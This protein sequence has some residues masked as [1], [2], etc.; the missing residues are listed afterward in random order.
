MN[1]IHLNTNLQI[2]FYSKYAPL[3][4]SFIICPVCP[5]PTC[6][7]NAK[8]VSGFPYKIVLWPFGSVHFFFRRAHLFPLWLWLA[9]TAQQIKS[10]LRARQKPWTLL[11]SPPSPPKVLCF[12]T[13]R[14]IFYNAVQ[15][16]HHYCK[17]VPVCQISSCFH[18]LS[19]WP[20]PFHILFP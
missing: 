2:T 1:G 3:E 4:T 11:T 5:G 18:C 20:V 7:F 14:P 9:D 12:T 13:M 19:Q 17:N 16:R 8:S 10:E 15:P 6:I